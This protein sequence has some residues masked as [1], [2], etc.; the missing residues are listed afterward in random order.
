MGS[1]VEMAGGWAAA[2]TTG[3]SVAVAAYACAMLLPVLPVLPLKP[4]GAAEC[5][6]ETRTALKWHWTARWA[7]RDCDCWHGVRTAPQRL[8]C[9]MPPSARSGSTAAI[10]GIL[11][12]CYDVSQNTQVDQG[13]PPRTSRIEV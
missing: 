6:A 13:E 2:A 3:G 12:A 5:T 11:V 10:K 4:T 8:R 7:S 9:V 1:G